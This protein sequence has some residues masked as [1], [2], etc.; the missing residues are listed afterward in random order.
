MDIKLSLK[1]KNED[2][3]LISNIKQSNEDVEVIFKENL[4]YFILFEDKINE[5]KV[6]INDF[7]SNPSVLFYEKKDKNKKQNGIII[8]N[9]EENN[10]PTFINN[11]KQMEEVDSNNNNAT[12]NII[13]NNHNNNQVNDIKASF[14]SKQINQNENI[15]NF[16]NNNMNNLNNNNNNVAN[17]LN[18]INNMNINNNANNNNNNILLNNN[19]NIQNNLNQN[20]DMKNNINIWIRSAFENKQYAFVSDYVRFFALYNYGGIYLDSDIEIIKSFDDL[21]NNKFFF[22][23]EY[24]GLPEA[25][26]I[27]AEKGLDWIKICLD[28]YNEHF[29]ENTDGSFNKIVAPLITQAG[30]EKGNKVKLLD[31]GNIKTINE[32][33]IFPINLL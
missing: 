15:P 3:D 5:I 18:N 32:G 11:Q 10:P 7:I 9:V 17:N 6:G 26:V 28:W 14:N 1:L 8:E 20:N 33:S 24:E 12:M 23:Y 16:N 4:N 25:A 2:F 27:G 29:F 31:D 30:F 22:C 19:M 21:L 13:Q